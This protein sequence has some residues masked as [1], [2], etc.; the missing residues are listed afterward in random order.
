MKFLFVHQNF[1]GQFLH[2]VR[3]LAAMRTH[4]IVF[5]TEANANL[6]EGVR[7]VPYGK[8]RPASVETHIVAREMDVAVRRAEIVA[9]TAN[10]A[11]TA[12]LHA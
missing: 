4:E 2:I 9:Y 5:I 3:H 6:M 11:E 1:P 8:P 7:K 10:V 12:R